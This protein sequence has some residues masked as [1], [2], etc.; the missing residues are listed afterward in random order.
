VYSVH[1][2]AHFSPSVNLVL[3]RITGA[4]MSVLQTIYGYSAIC[5]SSGMMKF[6]VG[7]SGMPE[8]YYYVS[9]VLTTFTIELLFQPVHTETYCLIEAKILAL[10]VRLDSKP[11]M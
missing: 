2:M 3:S 5:N 7:V 9:F 1:Q 10:V 4:K 8:R 6:K 11:D